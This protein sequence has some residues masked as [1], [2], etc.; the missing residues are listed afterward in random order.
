MP[1]LF[2]EVKIVFVSMCLSKN[3]SLNLEI[4]RAPI[5]DPVPPPRPCVIWKPWSESHFYTSNLMVFKDQ[6]IISAPSV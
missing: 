4:M 5:P 1:S 3:S 2:G 6:S